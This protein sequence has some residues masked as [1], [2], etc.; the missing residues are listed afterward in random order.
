ME[1]DFAQTLLGDQD[2]SVRLKSDL[3]F[4]RNLVDFELARAPPC[5]AM[6]GS[7]TSFIV[8]YKRFC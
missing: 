2:A 1:W 7:L 3:I 5:Y 8:T 6:A 4:L